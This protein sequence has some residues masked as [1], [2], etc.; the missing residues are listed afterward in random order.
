MILLCLE[1][2][3]LGVTKSITECAKV[4]IVQC[5]TEKCKIVQCSIKSVK[6]KMK[7]Y[8]KLLILAKNYKKK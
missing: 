5:S 4:R 6:K 1:V 7:G 2:K 8:L 3:I